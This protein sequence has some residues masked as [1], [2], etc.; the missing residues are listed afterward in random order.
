M[1]ERHGDWVLLVSSDAVMRGQWRTVLA[2]VGYSIDEAP[3]AAQALLALRRSTRPLV[4]LLDQ[5]QLTLLNAVL[6]DPR[7]A[8]HHAYLLLCAIEEECLDRV[9]SLLDQLMLRVIGYPSAAGML[10]E[11]VDRAARLLRPNSMYA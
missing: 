1:S 8:S 2:S 11:E 6:P 3:D 7:A 10:I 5:P 9:R 4:V